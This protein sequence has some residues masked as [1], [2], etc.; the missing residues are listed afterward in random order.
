[1]AVWSRCKANFFEKRWDMG[2]GALYMTSPPPSATTLLLQRRASPTPVDDDIFACMAA[3][4]RLRHEYD[5]CMLLS[6]GRDPRYGDPDVY[7][8]YQ[9]SSGASAPDAC[10]AFSGLSQSAVGPLRDVATA[11]LVDSAVSDPT[12]T[13]GGLCPLVTGIW[14]KAMPSKLPVTVQH[15]RLEKPDFIPSADPGYLEIARRMAAAFDA[16]NATFDSQLEH[17]T[18]VLFSADGDVL[19]DMMDCMFQGICSLLKRHSNAAFLPSLWH[20]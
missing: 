6:L 10:V 18:A 12:D 13:G 3:P 7:F 14:T 2:A 16:F 4:G 20:L 8:Q 1:M 15:G 11:C 19:H 17:L 5:D 9:H